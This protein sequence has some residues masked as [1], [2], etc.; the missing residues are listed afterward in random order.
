[1][2]L[3]M[4][5]SKDVWALPATPPPEAPVK[6]MKI[7]VQEGSHWSIGVGYSVSRVTGASF[8]VASQ[9][10]RERLPLPRWRPWLDARMREGRVHV[11]GRV[12][13]PPTEVSLGA[14]EAV[15]L[16]GARDDAAIDL[17]SGAARKTL[18]RLLAVGR[19]VP[20]PAGRL[21]VEADGVRC[22]VDVDPT[23][24]RP[25]QGSCAAAEGRTDRVCEH[26]VAACLR[27]PRLRGRLVWWAL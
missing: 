27:Q 6:G 5:S 26:V 19:F 12:L 15:P 22:E 8:Y 25:L 4:A 7:W 18:G 13:E 24:E 1:M 14:E 16:D 20:A 9:G 10:R 3:A 2:S 21:L 17:H 23:W 11:D